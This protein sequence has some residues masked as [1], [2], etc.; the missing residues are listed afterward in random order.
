MKN[1]GAILFRCDDVHEAIEASRYAPQGL[2]ALTFGLPS[3]H[4]VDMLECMLDKVT[5]LYA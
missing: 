3:F 4:C 2:F 5:V 1:T